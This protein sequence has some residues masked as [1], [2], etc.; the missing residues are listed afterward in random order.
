MPQTG[1]APQRSPESRTEPVRGSVFFK[2]I[3]WTSPRRNMLLGLL[4]VLIAYIGVCWLLGLNL[5][6]H[7]VYDS[8]T[9]QAM[10]WRQGRIALQ[11]DYPHLELAIYEGRYYVSFPPF[12]AVPMLLLTFVFGQNTPSRLVA[13]LL[14]VGSYLLGY[15]IA[16]R[17][18]QSDRNAALLSCFLTAGCNMMEVSLFGGVWNMA[19]VMG[20]FLTLAAVLGVESTRRSARGWGLVALAC[21]VGCRPFQ[22]VYVP[23]TLLMCWRAERREGTVRQALGRLAQL[24]IAPALIAVLYGAYNIV[25]F[26]NPLEFGH[27]YLP[28]FTRSAT[29]QFNLSN[30]PVNL[31]NILRLPWFENGL[32]LFPS[33]SGFAFY[34]ANPMFIAAALSAVVRTHDPRKGDRPAGSPSRRALDVIDGLILLLSAFHFVALLTHHSFGGVQFGTRYLCD[35][36]PALYLFTLRGRP[37]RLRGYEA[38]L[39]LWGIFFNIYGALVFHMHY[40]GAS[41]F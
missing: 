1:T 4:F 18:G 8:Y 29:G 38:P 14:F 39:I 37:W 28:E 23:L 41:R 25:R 40:L 17:H 16:R 21:A 22:A 26:G 27:N 31:R 6:E 9:L 32:L 33:A 11:R 3:Q 5:T 20:F 12:P 24:I 34:I 15:R 7:S 19:Q 35:L 36:I 10:T 13:M 30:I 2:L